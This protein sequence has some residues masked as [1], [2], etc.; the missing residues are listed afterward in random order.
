MDY[1]SAVVISHIMSSDDP[2]NAVDYIAREGRFAIG[3]IDRTVTAEDERLAMREQERY[4]DYIAREGFF[5]YRTQGDR[6]V[7]AG[8]RSG[9]LWGPHGPVS[10]EGLKRDLAASGLYMKSVVSVRREDAAALRLEGKEGW[11]GLIRAVW[12]RQA[13]EW[14]VMERSDIRWAAGYHV[15]NVENL[16]VHIVTYDA[17]GRW[18]ARENTRVPQERFIASRE[19]VRR[20]ALRPE[21][22]RMDRIDSALRQWSVNRVRATLGREVRP[23]SARDAAIASRLGLPRPD[24]RV[25]ASPTVRESA[26]AVLDARPKGDE[27]V[28]SYARSS[29]D[30]RDATDRAV[31]RLAADDPHLARA[32]KLHEENVRDLARAV[33]E[34]GVEVRN[35]H[36]VDREKDFVRGRERDFSGRLANAYLSSLRAEEGRY[37]PSQAEAQAERVHAEPRERM[38]QEPLPARAPREEAVPREDRCVPR[39]DREDAERDGGSGLGSLLLIAQALVSRPEGRESSAPREREDSPDLRSGKPSLSEERAMSSERMG[40]RGR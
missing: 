21:I 3:G 4:A 25:I 9:G 10:S 33:K 17:S 23:L 6:P 28:L 11:Q 8:E 19:I 12:D 18:A 34:G 29:K 38:Q 24:A 22:N 30:V 2:S 5:E 35:G 39:E 7:V 14:G 1:R 37:R 20:E 26:R 15:D 32:L 27:R 16:H 13:A 31:R 36:P 40:G